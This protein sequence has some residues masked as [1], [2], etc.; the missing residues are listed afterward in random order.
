MGWIFILG[1]FRCI[2][3][4]NVILAQFTVHSSRRAVRMFVPSRLSHNTSRLSGQASRCPSFLSFPGPTFLLRSALL[5]ARLLPPVCRASVALPDPSWPCW[6]PTEMLCILPTVKQWSYRHPA[7]LTHSFCSSKSPYQP[8]PGTLTA[9]RTKS[10]SLQTSASGSSLPFPSHLWLPSHALG[11]RQLDIVLFLIWPTFSSL[12]DFV[13]PSQHP[14]VAS[15]LTSHTLFLTQPPSPLSCSAPLVPSWCPPLGYDRLAVCLVIP[16]SHLSDAPCPFLFRVHS[17]IAHDL[18]DKVQLGLG[19]SDPL[20]SCLGH[21]HVWTLCANQ[22]CLFSSLETL[23]GTHV[24]PS[25]HS[26]PP[27]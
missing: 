8:L 2:I 20:Q 25:V 5:C 27:S 16:Y 3:E 10:N 4:I 21:S 7:L 22:N 23:G 18:H 19:P 15:R 17:G 14:K 9:L 1:K 6:L 12:H 24:T 26:L 11:W 13:L